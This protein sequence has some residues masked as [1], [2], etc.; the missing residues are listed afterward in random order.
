LIA[1]ARTLRRRVAAV[2]L[3]VGIAGILGGAAAD[4][5]PAPALDLRRA[6]A[7]AERWEKRFVPVHFWL[8]KSEGEE[9]VAGRG[10]PGA[11]DDKRPLDLAALAVDP[12]TLWLPDPSIEPRFIARITAG[13]GEIAARV[14][15]YVL[16]A[17]GLVLKTQAPLA[18]VERLEFAA[19]DA[20]ADPSAFLAVGAERCYGDWTMS[21]SSL[22]GRYRFRG[23]FRW[24]EKAAGLL[25][26]DGRGEAIGYTFSAAAGLGD[27]PHAWRGRDLA[28]A[29]V[30][31]LD[32]IDELRD[33]FLD[34]GKGRDLLPT[35]ELSFRR[36]QE[37]E[38]GFPF[39]MRYS[40]V[41]EDEEEL[42][43]LRLSGLAVGPR[44]VLVHHALTRHQ[45]M[46]IDAISVEL[47]AGER[48]AVFA[49]AFRDFGGFLVD[50]EGAPLETFL[51]LA[52][53]TRFSVHQPLIALSVDHE[54]GTRRHRAEFERV[55][56]FAQ[57][58]RNVREAVL[59][60]FP[61]HG[62]V[63][64]DAGG[65]SVVGVIV[66]V[67]REDEEESPF[68]RSAYY[69]RGAWRRA[70]RGFYQGV[71]LRALALGDLRGLLESA[72]GSFDPRLRPVAREREKDMV[73]YGV[74]SQ[75]LTR[76]LARTHKVEVATR[77]GE[78][79]SLVVLVHE[80]SPAHRGGIRPGDVLLSLRDLRKDEPVELQAGELEQ[81]MSSVFEE[82]DEVPEEMRE[83]FL[84]RM[85]PPWRSPRSA[86]NVAL[87]AIGAGSEVEI[88]YVRD[89]KTLTHR[90]TL[91]LGP[92]DFDSAPKEKLEE[93]GITVKDLTYE[94]RDHYRLDA[95]A[96]GVV[97][98][99][100]ESGSPV[101]VA[102][103][104]PYEIIVQVSG[105]PVRSASEFRA[106]VEKARASGGTLEFRVER[107]GKS[108]LVKI[109]V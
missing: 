3:L 17:P 10:D 81:E 45:A 61:R 101:A 93:L 31:A 85:P 27:S 32:A 104:L 21:V 105:E 52:R 1:M 96:P 86:L 53:E 39:R 9:P 64:L 23:E 62:A 18:G 92:P 5:P 49:G 20:S 89:G 97:V 28:G 47:A 48:R 54:S 80:G 58:Y 67:R 6:A 73:W 30:L 24:L 98:A 76:E 94:V 7:I 71:D 14:H 68:M 4:D 8:K 66:E 2:A 55:T 83:E 109:R 19:V 51:D 40:R 59:A 70:N 88:Q 29:G 103:V 26:L 16:P 91:E 84:S 100:V 15:G 69:R 77:G 44:R 36:E 37:D 33:H 78:I 35:V 99:K 108:R 60:P 12:E 87:D 90:L 79:G 102:K 11:Y 75:P 56:D 25:V 72:P 63:L 43:E 42:D 46:R 50:V 95:S 22:A 41:E 34:Q 74:E 57:G 107:L 82:I 13:D 106:L 65:Q 38:E